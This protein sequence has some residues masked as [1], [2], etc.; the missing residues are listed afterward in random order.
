MAESGSTRAISP[1]RV[2]IASPGD[3]ND[4]RGVVRDVASELNG[5]LCRHGWEIE[6]LGWENRGPTGGRAQADINA[7]VER[8]HIFIGILWQRWGTPTGGATSG[9][10]EEWGLARDRFQRSGAPDLWL[11]FKHGTHAS[12]SVDPVE[13]AR[14]ETFRREVADAEAAFY[15]SFDDLAAFEKL[16]R[17]RL[18][19]EVFR[20]NGLTRT[21]LGI[22]A[23]DWTS[24]YREDP[25]W[26][27]PHGRDRETL[28]NE[29]L[30]SR[31]EAAAQLW[32]ELADESDAAGL[33]ENAESLRMKASQALI[34]AGL[35]TAAVAS[36]RRVLAEH[37]W[38][39]RLDETRRIVD[40]LDDAWPPE[41]AS[42]LRGWRACSRATVDPDAAASTLT[43]E[44]TAS[45]AFPLDQVTRTHWTALL[46]RCDLHRGDV[47]R[48]AGATI[49]LE[50]ISSDVDLEV[51]L[52]WADG[53][54]AA[55]DPRA[56]EAW[57]TLRLR[58]IEDA[59]GAPA[60]SAW[61]ATRVAMDLVNQTKINDSEIAY[62][63]AAARW[64]QAPGGHE[65]ASLAFFSAQAA[66]QLSGEWS[67]R[68]W[69]LREALSTQRS[70]L[71]SFS[72][73]AARLEAAVRSRR[74][75]ENGGSTSMLTAALWM[76]RRA[77][78]LD[79]VMRD[80]SLLAE[81]HA[82]A[83]GTPRP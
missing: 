66:A 45:H 57:A 63:D 24:A 67:F 14:V 65:Q 59:R 49:D 32:G 6:L 18:T 22:L 82:S 51:G 79:G 12:R 53:L 64:A 17:E 62:V 77:G 73:R 68:G 35:N 8:C 78:L 83:G 58:A 39:L 3:V 13:L 50:A 11:Y 47:H 61:I 21:D 23:L 9:F 43:A 5:P 34:A 26:L 4:E 19:D 55:A 20:R 25:T 41:L 30:T 52:L 75:R 54:R 42:E 48:I 36:L 2:F 74:V 56:D 76:H 31:P 46:W 1:I 70:S 33:P 60:R 15:K 40:R 80:L 16:V 7:D 37:L 72:R 10:A 81:E 44:L 69:V 38:W 28:A 71:S 29:L 27:L